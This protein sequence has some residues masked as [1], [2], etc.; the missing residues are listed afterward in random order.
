MDKKIILAH[1]IP[2]GEISKNWTADDASK[3]FDKISEP[4]P[5]AL[6][7]VSDS[8]GKNGPKTTPFRE[9]ILFFRFRFDNFFSKIATDLV[10]Y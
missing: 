4:F 5:E 6:L 10:D 9:W 3:W 1:E 8:F 2:R 7:S